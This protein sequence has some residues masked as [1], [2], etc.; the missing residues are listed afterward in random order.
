MPGFGGAASQP[1]LPLNPT[2]TGTSMPLMP[3]EEPRPGQILFDR[4]L[5]ERLLGR[6]GMGSVWLVRHTDLDEHR[7]LKLII[8]DH[9]FDPQIL[10]RFRQEARSMVKLKSKNAVTVHNARISPAGAYIEMEYLDGR[11]L[12]E[13]IKRG[14]P[15]PPRMVADLLDQICEVLTE[16]HAL[17]IVHRDLKPSNLMLIPD[18]LRGRWMLKVVDFGIAKVSGDLLGEES[19]K[20]Q[21]DSFLGTAQYSSPEQCYHHESLD[22]RSD[23]YSVGVILY[24]LLT[25]YRPFDGGVMSLMQSHASKTP[26]PM[27]TRNPDAHVPPQIEAVVMRCLAKN[28]AERPQ[29]AG[30]LAESF[31]RAVIESADTEVA[32]DEPAP[33]P[34]PPEPQPTPRRHWPAVVG[35]LAL[36]VVAG[37]IALAVPQ[38]KS[39]FSPAPIVDRT[40]R[41]VDPV[42][43]P[44]SPSADLARWKEQG[45]RPESDV[46]SDVMP[47]TLV[48]EIAGVQHKYH[49]NAQERYYLPEGF[50]VPENTPRDPSDGW[51]SLIV[52]PDKADYMRIPGGQF[53]MG[54]NVLDTVEA[55]HEVE[56]SGFYLKRTEVTNGELSAY[57][58]AHKVK[59]EDLP[60]ERLDEM[61]VFKNVIA[62]MQTNAKPGERLDWRAEFDLH[63][64]RK[65]NHALASA[66]AE[67][68]GGRLPTE[69][70]WEYA[71]RSA[72]LPKVLFP[73]GFDEARNAQAQA[74]KPGP[75]NLMAEDGGQPLKPIEV[76]KVGTFPLDAT[77]QGVVDLAGN[78]REW[79]RDAWKAEV[80][81]NPSGAIR[82]PCVEP[83]K[84]KSNGLFAVRGGSFEFTKEGANVRR[85]RK[86]PGKSAKFDLGFRVVVET[87]YLPP[88]KAVAARPLP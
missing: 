79:C 84:D 43:K 16:A 34:Q 47:E 1:Q 66:Y 74:A 56:L 32:T 23:L 26:P 33:E 2:P 54:W 21:S 15:M 29:T 7:A 83:P 17:G 86:E 24:E 76:G 30:E 59:A 13:E 4:Y 88:L 20:T 12:N 65:V 55:E 85:R 67:W 68:V 31:R 81:S 8:P 41:P 37:G 18:R 46:A 27:A 28:P 6:G 77:K 58:E 50:K 3:R 63:P 61:E 39:W 75:A 25:G 70:Q 82:D 5:V 80:P 53:T 73:W 51:P 44:A 87:P 35:V 11:G 19:V 48:Y 72:G 38:W 9:E 14:V 42:S 78:V 36:V 22:S 49:W 52:G 40:P 10:A 71:V 57:Y 62:D 69:A 45:F 64:A 60:A